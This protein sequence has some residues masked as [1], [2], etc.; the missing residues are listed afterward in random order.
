MIIDA[1]I[2]NTL[3]GLGYECVDIEL[4][5]QGVL[6]IFIDKS[7]GVS[8]NDC[9]VVNQHLNH[10]LTVINFDYQRLEVS[11]PGLDR[12]LKKEQDFIRFVGKTAKVKTYLPINQQKKF[13]GKILSFK[14]H[15]LSLECGP[16][17]KRIDIPFDHIER[18]RLKPQ[19][20]KLN[21]LEDSAG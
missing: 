12:V 3:A 6:R 7:E 17:K 21:Q 8:I 11:S 10:L 14:D 20:D 19:F 16:H 9:V 5:P 13:S 4:T 1:Y 18:A 15:V 2:E